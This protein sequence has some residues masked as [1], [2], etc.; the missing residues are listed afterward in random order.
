MNI[1]DIV[2]ITADFFGLDQSYIKPV[3]SEDLKQPAKRPPVTGFIITKAMNELDFK[4]HSF[5]EGLSYV[6]NQLI[7]VGAEK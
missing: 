3:T 6:K 4:P 2:R 1:L 5:L 7:L